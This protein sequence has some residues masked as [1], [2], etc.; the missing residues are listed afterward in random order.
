[1]IQ[2]E[3]LLFIWNIFRIADEDLQYI[4]DAQLSNFESFKI[5]E[6]TVK[7]REIEELEALRNKAKDLYKRQKLIESSQVESVTAT[8]TQQEETTSDYFSLETTTTYNDLLD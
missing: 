7:S 1:M 6:K 5:P 2:I 8:T 3:K 4:I